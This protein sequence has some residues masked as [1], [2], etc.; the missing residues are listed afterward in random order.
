MWAT[1]EEEGG[2]VGRGREKREGAMVIGPHCDPTRQ[3]QGNQKQ[4]E[5]I[6]FNLL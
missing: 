4:R 5:K 3:R 6:K 2:E 1:V